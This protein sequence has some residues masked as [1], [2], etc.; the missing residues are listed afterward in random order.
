M[1]AINDVISTI[2]AGIK[3]SADI[4]SWSSANYGRVISVFE[5]CDPRQPPPEDACP[6]VIVYHLAKY[7]GANSQKKALSIGV[8]C[9]V[10]DPEKPV[11]AE[12]VVRFEGMRRAEELR[13]MAEDEVIEHIPS[14]LELED[15]ETEFNPQMDFPLVSAEMKLLITEDKLIGQSPF[16]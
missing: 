15:V 7:A 11:S 1:A 9:W 3:D 10:Y 13:D 8:A 14:A 16:K 2:C 12:G 6:L 5:N 4:A